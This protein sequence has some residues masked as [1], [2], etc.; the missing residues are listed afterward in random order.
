MKKLIHVIV[1]LMMCLSAGAQTSTRTME[2]VGKAVAKTIPEQIVIHIPLKIIDSSYS[3]CS[4]MLNRTLDNLRGDL[5]SKGVAE[6]HIETSNYRIRENI[7][8]ENGKRRQEGYAGMVTV[9]ISKTYTPEFMNDIIESV[10][11]YLL[12][13]SISYSMTEKQKE[14]LNKLVMVRAFKDANNKARVLSE[15]AGIKLG[16]ISRI[17]Y[18]TENYRIEPFTSERMVNSEHDNT[19]SGELILNPPLTS[20]YK[21]VFIVWEIKAE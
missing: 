5:L 12:T 9:V 16:D 11:K 15:A 21:S 18:G 20:L 6:E 4:Q 7:T 13:Y 3:N 14:D 10:Q 8:Y 19:G 1:L 2:V 17:S